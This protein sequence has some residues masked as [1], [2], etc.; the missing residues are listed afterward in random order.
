MLIFKKLSRNRNLGVASLRDDFDFL[1]D[2]INL[3]QYSL[4]PI[5]YSLKNA[6][7]LF[8]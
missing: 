1:L 8:K 5:P 2:F 4:F 6:I 7:R 3:Q